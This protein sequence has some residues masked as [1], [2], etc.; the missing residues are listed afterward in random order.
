LYDKEQYFMKEF[1][2]TGCLETFTGDELLGLPSSQVPFGDIRKGIG[3][4]NPSSRNHVWTNQLLSSSDW[5][6]GAFTIDATNEIFIM[7][8]R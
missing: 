1:G 4:S 5:G 8:E 3:A 2:K 7:S 6:Y